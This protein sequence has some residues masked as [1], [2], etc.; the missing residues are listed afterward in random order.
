MRRIK[1]QW[2]QWRGL[3]QR[4]KSYYKSVEIIDM[5]METWYADS[6]DSDA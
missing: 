3:T 4:F 2:K 5:Y 1:I 6:N